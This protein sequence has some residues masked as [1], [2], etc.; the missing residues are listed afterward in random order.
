MRVRLLEILRPYV[1]I[2]V[3]GHAGENSHA[4]FVQTLNFADDHVL[5]DKRKTGLPPCLDS[6]PEETVGRMADGE[7]RGAKAE[8]V[9]RSPRGREAD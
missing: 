7:K 8:A 6:T 1:P 5:C 2:K 4:S 3:G 9:S